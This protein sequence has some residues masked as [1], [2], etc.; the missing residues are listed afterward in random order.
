[1]DIPDKYMIVGLLPLGFPAEEGRI[2]TRKSLEE[3]IC[4][5][6]FSE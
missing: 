5:D 6:T 2:K 4:Y 1:M 3:I